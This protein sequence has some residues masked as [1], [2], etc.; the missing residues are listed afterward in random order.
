VT[1]EGLLQALPAL[2]SRETGFAE[3]DG[4]RTRDGF[5]N[6]TAQLHLGC[7]RP[8]CHSAP[9]TKTCQQAGSARSGLLTGGLMSRL[10]RPSVENFVRAGFTPAGVVKTPTS[11]TF[12]WYAA[13][14]TFLGLQVRSNRST[15]HTNRLP[16]CLSTSAHKSKP[17]GDA[18]LTAPAVDLDFTLREQR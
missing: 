7:N 14:P 8:L 3:R 2:Y 17:A 1:L 12:G 4:S 11:T 13:A 6:E 16:Q 10:T 5:V 9:Q 15:L 18:E